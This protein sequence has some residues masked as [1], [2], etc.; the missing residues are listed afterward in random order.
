MLGIDAQTQSQFDGLVELG[1]LDLLQERH[2][3]VELIGPLFHLR[4]CFGLV[5]AFSLRHIFPYATTSK[6]MLRAVPL[7]ERIAASSDAALRSDIFALAISATCFSV[8]LPT[9]VLFGS[10]DP[11]AKPAAFF[12][13]TDAGGVLVI[14][15]NERSE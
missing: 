12:S 3:F 5:L 1:V 6:P 4:F 14:K 7:I 9:L 15:L 10:P 8:I 13:N 11:L 2:R